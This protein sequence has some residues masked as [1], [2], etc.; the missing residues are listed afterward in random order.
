MAVVLDNA[1]CLP[2]ALLE[3]DVL[4]CKETLAIDVLYI[5]NL[6]NFQM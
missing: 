3:V 6:L 4:N 1:V 2:Q 5:L